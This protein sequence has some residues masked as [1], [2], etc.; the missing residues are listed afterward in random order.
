MNFRAMPNGVT[1]RGEE[2][3]GKSEGGGRNVGAMAKNK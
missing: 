2:W 3:A 1:V